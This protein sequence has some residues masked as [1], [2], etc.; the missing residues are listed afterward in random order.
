[1]EGLQSSVTIIN[2]SM[3]A[4]STDQIARFYKERLNSL[5]HKIL[6]FV[7]HLDEVNRELSYRKNHVLYSPKWPEWRQDFTI[8]DA[9]AA[10]GF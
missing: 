4:Y 1:M 6:V 3:P 8:M 7:F 2:G 9:I 10:S 5:P